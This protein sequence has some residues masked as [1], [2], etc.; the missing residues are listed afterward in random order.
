MYQLQKVGYVINGA[1]FETQKRTI[2]KWGHVI[3]GAICFSYRNGAV[4]EMGQMFKSQKW[5]NVYI[6]ERGLW[7]CQKAA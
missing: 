4:T 6:L 7:I 1:M 2:Q 3:N 5:G